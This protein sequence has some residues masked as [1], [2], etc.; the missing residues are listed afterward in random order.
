MRLQDSGTRTDMLE[1]CDGTNEGLMGWSCLRRA[2][3][4][5]ISF[6]SPLV[7]FVAIVTLQ[8]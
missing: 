4:G 3:G 6:F 8:L 2:R 7:P 5:F 1:R